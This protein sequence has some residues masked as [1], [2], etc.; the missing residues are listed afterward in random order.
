[1]CLPIFF[2][3]D[4]DGVIQDLDLFSSL[5]LQVYF[6]FFNDRFIIFFLFLYKEVIQNSEVSSRG[7]TGIAVSRSLLSSHKMFTALL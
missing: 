1:M 6:S 4:F 2:L 3:D 7:S 5:I